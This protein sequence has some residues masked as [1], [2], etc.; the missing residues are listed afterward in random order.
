M[1]PLTSLSLLQHDTFLK[2]KLK[3]IYFS[4]I[5]G[6]ACSFMLLIDQKWGVQTETEELHM[7]WDMFCL[8]S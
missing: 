6:N 8:L 1:K 7:G 5:N 3:H 2:E 4:N